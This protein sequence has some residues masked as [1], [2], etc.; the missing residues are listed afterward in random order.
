MIINIILFLFCC[1]FF[2]V[3]IISLLFGAIPMTIF[4]VL[5]FSLCY[6]GIQ[7]K[8]PEPKQIHLTYFNGDSDDGDGDEDEIVPFDRS[9][10]EYN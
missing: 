3:G 8:Q 4:C 7:Y 2:L 9:N 1:F 6:Y 5:F 10:F